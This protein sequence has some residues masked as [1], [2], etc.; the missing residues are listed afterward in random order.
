AATGVVGA[1]QTLGQ[2]ASYRIDGGALRYSTSNTVTDAVDGV[3]LT[4][5]D[6]T[7]ADVTVEVS[8]NS[9]AASDAVKEFVSQ[10]NKTMELIRGHT[11]YVEDGNNGV[12]FGDSTM[13]MIDRRLRS[14]LISPV[15]GFSGDIRTLGDVGLTFGAVGSAVGTTDTLV[16]N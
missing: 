13:R 11:K 3:T 9:Q 4:L 1:T 6:T 16:F 7:T 12:L 10:Y 2:N 15:A 8:S 14:I 5:H